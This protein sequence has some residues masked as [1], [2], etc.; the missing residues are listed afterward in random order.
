VLF[1]FL[2]EQYYQSTGRFDEAADDYVFGVSI[3]VKLTG[4][5]AAEPQTLI[6]KPLLLRATSSVAAKWESLTM[7][8]DWQMRV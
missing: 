5:V 1:R 8:S 2:R 4:Y 6:P 7:L 3:V